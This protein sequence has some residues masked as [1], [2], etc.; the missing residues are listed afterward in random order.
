[1]SADRSVILSWLSGLV[2]DLVGDDL[3]RRGAEKRIAVAAGLGASAFAAE[4]LSLM[5]ISAESVSSPVDFDRIAAPSVVDQDTA[6]AVSILLATRLA[7]AG[8]KVEWPSRPQARSARGR[9]AAAGE[10]ALTAASRLGAEGADL[11]AW[12]ANLV[13]VSVRVVSEIAAN[14]VPVVRV[15]TKISLPSTALAYQLYGDAGRAQGLVEIAGSAT[16][17]LMPAAF[18]ALAN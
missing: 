6:D 5:R 17:L 11:Y 4:A 7:V 12:L 13:A 2:A 1:M 16:P 3:D 9:I 18:D 14:A 10:G 15:E 8:V